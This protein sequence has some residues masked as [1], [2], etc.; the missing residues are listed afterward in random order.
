MTMGPSSRWPGNA[1]PPGG[2]SFLPGH[3]Q[4]WRGD[5][6]WVPLH[7][8]HT[9]TL[10]VASSRGTV[11]RVLTTI[12]WIPSA[13]DLCWSQTHL[14]RKTMASAPGQAWPLAT[15]YPTPTSESRLSPRPHGRLPRWQAPHRGVRSLLPQLSGGLARTPQ[16]CELHL[17][18]LKGKLP[19]RA[20]RAH[21]LP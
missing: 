11:P 12:H 5:C 9:T 18:T 21:G 15:S 2:H 19:D 16:D 14:K 3:T 7:S 6:C 8:G 17:S 10:C 13:K 20:T 4:A 1:P